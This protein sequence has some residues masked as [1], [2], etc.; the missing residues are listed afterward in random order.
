MDCFR[1]TFALLCFA[2]A[3]PALLCTSAAR[4]AAALLL[5]LCFALLCFALLCFAACFALLCFACFFLAFYL[6]FALLCFALLCF[7]RNDEVRS[8]RKREITAPGRRLAWPLPSVFSGFFFCLGFQSRAA[9]LPS[10]TRTMSASNERPVL[11]LPSSVLASA[12]FARQ[13]LSRQPHRRPA[14]PPRPGRVFPCAAPRQLVGDDIELGKLIGG[15]GRPGIN[16]RRRDGAE[17]GEQRRAFGR[18]RTPASTGTAENGVS[19][20]A[21][22]SPPASAS[23]SCAAGRL[24][25]GPQV[26]SCRLGGSALTGASRGYRAVP[27]AGVSQ[28]SRIFG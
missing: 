18:R 1:A 27:S 8:L 19:V 14:L 26:W 7:A 20:P 13:A 23:S 9:G 5:L 12:P 24:R 15:A 17:V 28:P 16:D 22:F 3:L 10:A 11:V 25:C 2:F 4:F 21:P 6:C